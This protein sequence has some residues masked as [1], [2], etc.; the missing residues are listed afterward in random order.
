MLKKHW[1]NLEN[2]DKK[3]DLKLVLQEICDTAL[4][5]YL[6]RNSSYM[7]IQCMGTQMR[8]FVEAVIEEEYYAKKLT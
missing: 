2:A 3:K 4:H 5:I 7:Y 8:Y 6:L 1:P